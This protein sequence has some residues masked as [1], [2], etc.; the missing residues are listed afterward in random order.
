[1]GYLGKAK[2]LNFNPNQLENLLA[3]QKHLTIPNLQTWWLNQKYGRDGKI[4]LIVEVYI[5]TIRIPY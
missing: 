2:L 1:M 5:P 4:N 3:K